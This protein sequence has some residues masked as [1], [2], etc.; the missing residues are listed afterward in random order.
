MLR[1]HTG[2]FVRVFVVARR[3]RGEVAKGVEAKRRQEGLIEGQQTLLT[4][5]LGTTCAFV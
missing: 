5:T 3:R 2:R 1:A 4:G